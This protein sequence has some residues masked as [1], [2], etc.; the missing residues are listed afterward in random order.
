MGTRKISINDHLNTPIT[1][2]DR[3]RFK[4]DIILDQYSKGLY[5]ST[6]QLIRLDELLSEDEDNSER[7]DCIRRAK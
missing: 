3:K 4:D 2:Y 7:F 5:L 6:K 1:D